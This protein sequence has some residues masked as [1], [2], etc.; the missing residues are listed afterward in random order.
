MHLVLLHMENEDDPPASLGRRERKKIETRRSIRRVA[1]DLALELGMENLTIEAITEAAD[2]SPRTFFNYFSSKEDALV[3]DSAALADQIKPMIEERPRDES[4]L[5]SLR[6]VLTEHDPLL[7]AGANRERTLARQRLVQ[8]HPALMSR[9]LAQHAAMERHL[10]D[11]LAERLG[12]DADEDL[13][14]ALLAAVAGSIFRVAVRRWTEGGS[15][16]LSDLVNSAF[17]LIEQ[18]KLNEKPSSV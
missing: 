3:T 10:A 17:D 16:S 2:V 18:G 6:M 12:T 13:Q 11:V 15:E 4:P 14:P 1:L 7:L 9:Q 5:H 8:D